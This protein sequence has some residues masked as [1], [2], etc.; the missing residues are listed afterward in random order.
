VN[1]GKYAEA[2]AGFAKALAIRQAIGDRV[3]EAVAWHQ[4][5]TID[6]SE[7]KYAE[8][9]AGFAKALVTNQAVGNRAGEAATWH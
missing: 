1:E 5:A 8:A 2:R 3:G 4:L 7:G 6:L 9:R